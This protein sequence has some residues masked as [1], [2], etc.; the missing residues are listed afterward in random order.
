MPSDFPA[1]ELRCV[2]VDVCTI[3]FHGSNQIAERMP[4][5]RTDQIGGGDAALGEDAI[6]LAWNQHGWWTR[7]V[8]PCYNG[9]IDACGSHM[10]VGLQDVF[11]VGSNELV[12]QGSSVAA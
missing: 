3:R 2:D 9:T 11:D 8:Q 7:R 4:R 6:E 5:E 10:Y 12:V 1:W